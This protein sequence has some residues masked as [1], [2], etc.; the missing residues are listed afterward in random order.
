[1]SGVRSNVSRAARLI[2]PRRVELEPESPREPGRGEIRVRIEGCGLC[3]SNLPVW[4][5]RPWFQ[6]PLAPGAPGHEGWGIVEALGNEPGESSPGGLAVGDRV[7]LLSQHAFAEHDTACA[8]DA[9]KLPASLAGQPFPGEPLAC[10]MNILRRSEIGAGQT[11]AVV[12]IGFIGAA[13]TALAVRAGARVIALSRR[14]YALEMAERLGASACI[15]LDEPAKAL[16]EAR[17]VAGD[18]GC[19]RVIEAVGSQ[20][21]LDLA[22]ELTGTRARLIIAG[23]HQ[24]GART[25]DLQ[26]WNWRGIDVVNAHE[27]DP[28][29][30]RRGLQEAVHLVAEGGFDLSALCTHAFPIEELS[31]AFEALATRPPGFLKAWIACA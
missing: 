11:V 27:R 31:Q 18:A 4:E 1:L 3:G 19:E 6:Y 9:V 20:E 30:Y 23:Y 14:P 16:A 24:D 15:G 5:G 7:A 21:A 22:S 26:Q 10:V 17:R 8:A 28:A 25:V 29:E 2:G 13:L 12:G